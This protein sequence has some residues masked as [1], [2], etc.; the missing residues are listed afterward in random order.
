[1]QTEIISVTGFAN[2]YVH[3]PKRLQFI[4]FDHVKLPSGLN[5]SSITKL[6]IVIDGRTEWNISF[7]IVLKSLFHAHLNDKT[8]PYD[9]SKLW[10]DSARK[11]VI[12]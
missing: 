3:T 2:N 4:T 12:K 10:H 1:M 9:F 11:N 6:L 5:L 8:N 7:S